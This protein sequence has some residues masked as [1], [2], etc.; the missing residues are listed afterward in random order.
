MADELSRR[1]IPVVLAEGPADEA[2]ARDVLDLCA[3]KPAVIGGQ[4]LLRMAGILAHA[5]LFIGHDSGLTH[6][7]AAL[8]V[9][10]VGLFG[11]TDA[12]RWAPRGPSV[13]VLSGP[14][15]QCKDWQAVK[16]CTDKPC[17]RIAPESILYACAQFLPEPASAA[18]ISGHS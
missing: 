3:V 16:S 2:Q 6:L 12:G 9:P 8:N 4:E 14:P 15:C 17:L 11:P 1:G 5:T 13:R 10:T 18:G 7:A